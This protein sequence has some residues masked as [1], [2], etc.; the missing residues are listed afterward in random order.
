MKWLPSVLLFGVAALS[1][2]EF[3]TPGEIIPFIQSCRLE[4]PEESPEHYAMRPLVP[5]SNDW[6]DWA[7]LRGYFDAPEQT[8]RAVANLGNICREIRR[9]QAWPHRIPPT[10]EI[11]FLS[12]IPLIDGDIGC[13]EWRSALT[14]PVRYRKNDAEPES[15]P[16]LWRIGWNKSTL[17]AAVEVQAGKPKTLRYNREKA[18][19]PWEADCAEFFFMPPRPLLVYRELIFSPERLELEAL[20]HYSK[21]LRPTSH[22][23]TLTGLRYALKQNETGYRIEMAIPFSALP[24]YM[25]GNAP[26][27][28]DEIHFLPVTIHRGEAFS[29]FPYL[30]DGHNIFCYAK[31]TL[32]QKEEQ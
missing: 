26:K 13:E 31:G 6:T 4:I 25:Q 19:K 11:P 10:V 32:K 7:L 22:E 29:P 9:G 2:A 14:L 18:E 12:H 28:G 17:F 24:N 27:A 23:G 30:Y 3:D 5:R 8:D 21:Y 1:G 20:H 16:S 15:F